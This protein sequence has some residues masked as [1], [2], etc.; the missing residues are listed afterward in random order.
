M[1]TGSMLGLTWGLIAGWAGWRL[2]F[3]VGWALY[4]D[5]RYW[6]EVV[7]REEHEKFMVFVRAQHEEMMG[8]MRDAGILPPRHE[9]TVH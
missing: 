1:D 7:A 9:E 3:H 6:E 4:C 5:E 2:I 8:S